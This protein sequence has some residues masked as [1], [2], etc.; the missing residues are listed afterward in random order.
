MLQVYYNIQINSAHCTVILVL[1]M[2]LFQQEEKQV[3]NSLEKVKNSA[4]NKLI[5]V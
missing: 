2:L 5:D 3:Q 4:T 1:G